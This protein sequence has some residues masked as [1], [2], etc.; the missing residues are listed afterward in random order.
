MP[1]AIAHE[2]P[3]EGCLFK[4]SGKKP[5][6]HSLATVEVRVRSSPING[7][8]EVTVLNISRSAVGLI[9]PVFIPPGTGISFLFG[10]DRAFVEVRYCCVASR[11][12]LCGIA[13][14]R[15]L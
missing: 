12:F 5:A 15:P 1:I 10:G 7:L 13:E 4:T 14:Y 6:A 2:A 8:M 11:G 9:T 3:T